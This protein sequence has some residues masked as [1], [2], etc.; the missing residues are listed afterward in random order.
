MGE[1]QGVGKKKDGVGGDGRRRAALITV[2]YY[3]N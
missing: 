2:F 3:K 1:H